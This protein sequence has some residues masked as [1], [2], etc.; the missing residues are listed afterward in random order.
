M[1]GPTQN[2]ARNMALGYLIILIV[3]AVFIVAG[4]GLLATG[5]SDLEVVGFASILVGAFALLGVLAALS[6][7]NP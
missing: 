1:A 2:K 4:A 3:F 7:L 6:R 5:T